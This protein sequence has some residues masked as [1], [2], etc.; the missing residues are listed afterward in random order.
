MKTLF[1]DSSAF[2]AWADQASPQGAAIKALLLKHKPH[3]ITTNF[4]IAETLSLIT[5]RIGKHAGLRFGESVATSQLI[6]VIHI[7]AKTQQEGWQLYKQYQDKDFDLIDAIS[8]VICKRLNIQE[9]LT[10][11]HHFAQMTFKTL[12]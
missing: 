9:V 8:F 12:P 11:D 6:R 10:L 5:K 2:F 1:M 3:L 7:D 4:I